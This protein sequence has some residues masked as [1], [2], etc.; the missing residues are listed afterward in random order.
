MTLLPTVPFGDKQ[1][2]RLIIGGNP[3]RG[4]SHF[5][6]EM[7]RDMS[8]FY[9]VAR[10]KEVL[11]S[12]ERHGINTVQARG[13]ALV[14]QCIRE[15]WAEGGTMHFIV[16]TASEFRDLHGHVEHLAEFGSLG[17]YIHGTFTDRHFQEGDLVEVRDLAKRIRDAGVQV[18]LGTHIPEVVD[19]AED[20]GWDLDFY[21]ACMYNLSVKPRESAIVSGGKHQ[22]EQFDHGDADKM[23]ARIRA[24]DKTCLA[25]KVLGASRLCQRPEDVRA[26]FERVLTEIKPD[27]AMVV[28][29]FP[30]YRDEIEENTRFVREILAERAELT[31]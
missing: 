8:S 5:S 13:D 26:A 11:F 16:Q 19:Q 18:G 29:M 10:I 20:E 24:T 3:F 7:S 31:V 4:N 17:I 30:K 22:K 21:M 1:V 14:L 25:F 2:S 12:A 6:P 15:Y 28:G 9:T 27:D 23:L